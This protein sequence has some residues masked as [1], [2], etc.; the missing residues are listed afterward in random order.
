MRNLVK[1]VFVTVCN[2][3]ECAFVSGRNLVKCVFLCLCVTW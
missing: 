3:V 2:L 1:C